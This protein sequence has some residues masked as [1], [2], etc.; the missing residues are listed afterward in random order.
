LSNRLSRQ[1]REV[2]ACLHMLRAWFGLCEVQEWG[3]S[4]Y[5]FGVKQKD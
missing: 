1:K 4:F 2:I 3:T 5:Y